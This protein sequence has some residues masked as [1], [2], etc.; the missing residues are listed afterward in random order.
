ML[1]RAVNIV[2]TTKRENFKIIAGSCGR[3]TG[4]KNEPAE[5][6]SK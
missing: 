1:K 3:E 6:K 5:E 4:K 2:V